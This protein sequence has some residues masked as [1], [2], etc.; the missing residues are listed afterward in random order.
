ML[1]EKRL[2]KID[3]NE[4]DNKG[5]TSISNPNKEILWILFLLKKIYQFRIQIYFLTQYTI[6]PTDFKFGMFDS[7]IAHNALETLFTS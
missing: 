2:I 3:L 7:L 4:T 5:H 6:E 1:R